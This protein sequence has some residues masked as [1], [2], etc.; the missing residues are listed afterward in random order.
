MKLDAFVRALPA[1][2][3]IYDEEGRYLE[4]MTNET[5][6]LRTDADKLKG[7]LIAEVMPAAVADLMLGAIQ[8]AIETDT[9]QVIEYQI[10][11]LAG[12][13]R[14]FEGRVA[15]MEKD[16]AG[17]SKVVFIAIEISERVQLYHEV[18]RLANQDPLTACFNRRHFMSLAEQELQRAA[19][20][21][22]PLSLLMLDIDHFKELNDRH[23]HQV[24]DRVL[25]E[26]VTLCQKELR[27]IDIFGRYGGEE[28]IIL[29]P[30][31]VPS[32]GM[33]AAERLREKIRKMEIATGQE[34]LLITV[35][36]GVAG[37]DPGLS[38]AQTLDGLI[39]CADQGLYAAK[40]A[41]RNCVRAR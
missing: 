15:L 27:N 38:P 4:I 2:S 36:M 16:A 37:L 1:L 33:K 41:G 14:W 11:V 5:S 30:E 19:R 28:F 7:H 17:H 29:M 21:L 23:G 6:L 12:G 20:Y 13:E 3:F 10:P 39:K 35:S 32:S 25:C 26:L 18:Q 40:A 8:R 22:R 9:T 31:T 34:K 24:G